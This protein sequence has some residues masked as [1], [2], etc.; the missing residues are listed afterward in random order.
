MCVQKKS[1]AA[2]IST[3]RAILSA[4]SSAVPVPWTLFC[5]APF[6][7]WT[8]HHVGKIKRKVYIP[9]LIAAR[10]LLKAMGCSLFFL[11][12]RHNFH[13]QLR[14]TMTEEQL[15]R[16]SL[17]RPGFY[18]C[19]CS[20]WLNGGS[21]VF[22]LCLDDLLQRD[23]QLLQVIDIL[24]YRQKNPSWSLVLVPR[25]SWRDETESFGSFFWT[26]FFSMLLLKN[27]SRPDE[28]MDGGGAQETFLWQFMWVQR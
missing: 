15:R 20:R 27:G 8:F 10:Q 3:T 11:Q 16:R 4:A 25:C 23:V 1:A 19:L 9:I 24:F 6:T 5:V 28:A 12:V 26:L 22:L 17:C 13:C 21:F 14:E 18:F 2:Y 7:M